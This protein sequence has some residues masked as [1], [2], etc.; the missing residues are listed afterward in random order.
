[1]KI[2][3]SLGMFMLM[4]SATANAGFM[5]EPYVGYEM[6]TMEQTGTE[7][8]DNKGAYYGARLGYS[9]VGL[10]FGVDYQTGSEDVEQGGT[11]GDYEPTDLGVF[12]GY[13]LP[14]MLQVYASYFFDSKA[15]FGDSA[16]PED[17]TG[18]GMRFGIGWTGLPLVSINLEIIKRA[19][20][21]YNG[22]ALSGDLEGSSTALSIS[23]P[24]P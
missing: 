4:F 10:K 20:D 15:Q 12:V 3:L 1:M 5:I 22:T 16:F 18:T 17:F 23:L 7:D 9:L 6:G 21:E 11:S 24:L 14:I 2:L 8:L 19:Y 13:E